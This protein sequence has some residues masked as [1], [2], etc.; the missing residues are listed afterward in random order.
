MKLTVTHE[1]APADAEFAIAG[2]GLFK[3][4]ESRDVTEEQ[5]QA[6]ESINGYPVDEIKAEYVKIGGKATLKAADNQGKTTEEIE[7]EIDDDEDE[8]DE[9][10]ES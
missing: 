1:A 4:G 2:L 10:G 3:N 6:F 5:E 9:G 8:D 7:D